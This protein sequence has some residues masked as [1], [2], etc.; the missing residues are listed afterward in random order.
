MI[1]PYL[2]ARLLSVKPQPDS[3]PE[4]RR[5]PI[6]DETERYADYPPKPHE[7][8]VRAAQLLGWDFVVLGNR[9]EDH[10]G[11]DALLGPCLQRRAGPEAQDPFQEAVSLDHAT[12]QRSRYQVPARR[13][14]AQRVRS[15]ASRPS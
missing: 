3:S 12:R 9:P 4:S 8:D 14:P 2:A 1:A 5:T 11:R 7:V 15:A 13:H 10:I 6:V